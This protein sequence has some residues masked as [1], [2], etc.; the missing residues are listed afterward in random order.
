MIASIGLFHVSSATALSLIVYLIALMVSLFGTYV[1]TN[2]PEQSDEEKR[3]KSRAENWKFFLYQIA[4]GLILGTIMFMV[5][6]FQ[7][8]MSPF[9]SKAP[10]EAMNELAKGTIVSYL[11]V[12]LF[13]LII[14]F[15]RSRPSEWKNPAKWIEDE[16]PQKPVDCADELV[17]IEFDEEELKPDPAEET[18]A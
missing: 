14:A 1:V 4:G 17:G 13:A 9:S 15:I 5:F 12:L 2:H 8:P 16:E 7:S 6:L 10:T 11:L 18:K 3:N